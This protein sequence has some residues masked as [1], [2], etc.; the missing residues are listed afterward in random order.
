LIVQTVPSELVHCPASAAGP[1]FGTVSHPA[2]IATRTT[3][4]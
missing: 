3:A 2:I 4:K 1:E